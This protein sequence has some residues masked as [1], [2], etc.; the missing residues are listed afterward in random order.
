MIHSIAAYLDYF[1]GIR[2]RTVHY[3]RAVPPDR[4]D[5]LPREGEFTCGDIVRHL[6]AAEKMYVGLVT[7]YHWRYGGHARGVHN[8]LEEVI[9]HLNACHQ[10]SVAALSAV[11]DSYL[12]EL[13]V[14]LSPDTPPVRVWRGLMAMVEHEV[15]HRSQLASYLTWMGVE[16]PQIYG[17]KVE[18]IIALAGE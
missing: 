3:I 5:W 9:A 6:A 18:D 2:R 8:T 4:I 1:E 15:H 12:M 13:R 7:N 16:P 10:E 11:P 14:A 17:I